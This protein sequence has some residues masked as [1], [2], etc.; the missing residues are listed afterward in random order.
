VRNLVLTGSGGM[1]PLIL[2]IGKRFES[3]HAGVRVDVQSGGSTR[4][5]SD[6]RNGL[7]DIGMVARDLKPDETSLHATP[8]ARDGVCFIVNRA[9]AVATLTDEQIVRMYTRGVSSWKQVGGPELP[10]T[11]VNMAEGQ[12]LLELFLDHFKLKSTQIRADASVNDSDQGIRAVAGRPGAI[13]YV[14]CGRAE[15]VGADTPIKV[16]P[17]GG[18]TPTT[19]HVRDGTYPLSRPLNLVTR[20]APAGIIKEFID[21]ARSKDVVDL[22]EK[23][24]FVP[25]E[26]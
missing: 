5:A 6:V 26:K 9:N 7:A 19:E 11:L 14:S 20:D 10:I 17:S 21:F 24:H 3:A 1:E 25:L 13:A 4:G 15:A 23:Y 8:I 18:I 16:L 22:I 12:A 2:E